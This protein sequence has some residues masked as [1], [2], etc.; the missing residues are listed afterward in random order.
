MR[1]T[2]TRIYPSYSNQNISF[3]DKKSNKVKSDSSLSNG[4]PAI[5]PHDLISKLPCDASKMIQLNQKRQ[6]KGLRKRNAQIEKSIKG[7]NSICF[8]SSETKRQIFSERIQMESEMDKFD[9]LNSNKFLTE[10]RL[11]TSL[12]SKFV[13]A[14]EYYSESALSK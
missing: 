7:T 12:G 8:S 1:L 14:P 10:G 3:F 6:V 9:Q 11:N 13:S 5:M 4:K 2:A